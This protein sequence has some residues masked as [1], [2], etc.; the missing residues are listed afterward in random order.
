MAHFGTSLFFFLVHHFLMKCFLV[1]TQKLTWWNTSSLYMLGNTWCL[2]MALVP[3]N[4]TV[5]I[6]L[7]WAEN[8]LCLG[9]SLLCKIVLRINRKKLIHTYMDLHVYVYLMICSVVNNTVSSITYKVNECQF[10]YRLSLEFGKDRI[11]FQKFLFEHRHY[12]IL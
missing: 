9:A 7:P 8:I 11:H 10:L 1:M 6:A 2:K 12:H 3:W 5:T 4:N